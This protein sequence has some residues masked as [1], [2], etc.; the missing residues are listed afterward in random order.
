MV[1][2]ASYPTEESRWMR[3]DVI[4]RLR[5]ASGLPVTHV[6]VTRAEARQ[7]V[8][9]YSKVRHVLVVGNETIGEE[10]L[11]EEL[12]RRADR[13]PVRYTILCPL[14]LTGPDWKDD[15]V[16][17]RS[18]AVARVR[19]MIDLLQNSG[20]HA[21]GEVVDGPPL[22]E[23]RS[24]LGRFR[25]DEVLISTFPRRESAWLADDLIHRVRAMSEV[26]VEHIVVEA[27]TPAGSSGS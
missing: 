2:V 15:A 9:G 23:I 27:E 16:D 14:N 22:D 19:R 3:Q 5:K 25:P 26:P 21:E 24:A 11:V 6:V 7:P 20:I 13:G 8:S 10:E 4:D 12:L 17:A 18:A 1:V